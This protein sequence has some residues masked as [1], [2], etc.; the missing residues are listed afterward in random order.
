MTRKRNK[1]IGIDEIM[2][3]NPG[4]P[5]RACVIRRSWFPGGR[6]FLSEAGALY[7]L[8]SPDARIVPPGMGSLVEG[9]LALAQD[10]K[11]YCLEFAPQFGL[12]RVR[13]RSG[14]HLLAK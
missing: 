2:I 3:V 8:I 4:V 13:L 1:G 10:G 5:A 12:R 7:E 14:R 9:T 6:F 11:L